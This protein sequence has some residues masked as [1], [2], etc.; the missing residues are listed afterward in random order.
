V[1]FDLFCWQISIIQS[2]ESDF[3][4]FWFV[5]L[6]KFRS[7]NNYCKP[8][9]W[10]YVFLTCFFLIDFWMG[11]DL[12]GSTLLS[13]GSFSP[14]IFGSDKNTFLTHFGVKNSNSTKMDVCGLWFGRQHCE[15]PFFI[16]H[17]PLYSVLWM[18]FYQFMFSFL[19]TFADFIVN[20]SKHK[21][22]V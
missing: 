22:A 8:R 10:L 14:Q 16:V 19:L 2:L 18:T 3:T 9:K 11:M 13:R 12:R 21:A 15:W 1:F 5:F 4:C 20:P 7:Y 6:C 17:D